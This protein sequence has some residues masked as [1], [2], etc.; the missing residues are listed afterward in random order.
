M[1]YT[2]LGLHKYQP[3]FIVRVMQPRTWTINTGTWMDAN[4]RA[5]IGVRYQILMSV[6]S[7]AM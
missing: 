2:L 4:S 5:V 1:G 3:K 7:A 6:K